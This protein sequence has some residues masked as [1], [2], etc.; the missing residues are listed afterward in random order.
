MI[1]VGVYAVVAYH[2]ALKAWYFPAIFDNRGVGEMDWGSAPVHRHVATPRTGTLRASATGLLAVCG[3]PARR[4]GPPP[5]AASLTG[6]TAS[7]LVAAGVRG[8]AASRGVNG[9]SRPGA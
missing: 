7:A 1:S 6:R 8:E 2:D 9:A 3:A 4:R 5:A